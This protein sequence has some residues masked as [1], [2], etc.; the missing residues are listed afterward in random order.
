MENGINIVQKMIFIYNALES[1]WVVRKVSD[2][3]YEFKKHK[4]EVSHEVYLEKYVKEFIKNNLSL[5]NFENL[6]LNNINS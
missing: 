5:R 3:K 1:G 4:D 2:D 6:N